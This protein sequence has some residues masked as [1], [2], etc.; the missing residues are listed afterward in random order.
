MNYFEFIRPSG[1][2]AL[3]SGAYSFSW[4]VPATGWSNPA[5]IKANPQA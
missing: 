5:R 4:Q 1:E 2:D 3:L